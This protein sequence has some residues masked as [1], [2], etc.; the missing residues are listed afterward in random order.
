MS[1]GSPSRG[2]SIA[3]IGVFVM[4][5]T[6]WRKFPQWGSVYDNPGCLGFIPRLPLLLLRDFRA[7][8]MITRDVL[9]LFPRFSSHKRTIQTP[10]MRTE[11]RGMLFPLAPLKYVSSMYSNTNRHTMYSMYEEHQ[12]EELSSL[13]VLS[14]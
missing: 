13:R 9:A 3:H 1:I 11:E 2:E 6:N 14:V 4:E 7:S 10:C 8:Q 5:K 12:R